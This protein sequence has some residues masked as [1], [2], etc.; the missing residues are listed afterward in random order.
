MLP[1]TGSV[2]GRLTNEEPSATFDPCGQPAS[3]LSGRF[4]HF[5]WHQVPVEDVAAALSEAVPLPPR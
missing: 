3:R 4:L 5:E 1:G 2:L